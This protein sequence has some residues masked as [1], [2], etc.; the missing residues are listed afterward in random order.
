M[1]VRLCIR[2]TCLLGLAAAALF[3]C[4]FPRA[5]L[6]APGYPQEPTVVEYDA[7][8]SWPKRPDSV[9]PL[10]W[11]SGLAIDGKNQVWLFNKGEDPVQVYTTDGDFVRTWGKGDFKDPHQLRIDP[12]GNIW[13]ADF[14][15]HVVRKYTPEGK[16]LLTLGTLGEKG[17]DDKHFN[18]P[19]DMA[20]TKKGDIF[21]T[22]GYGNRRIVHFDKDGK[23]V[24]AW[25]TYGSGKGQ[26]VLPHAIALD[27]KELL[28][29]ADRNSGRIHVFEQSG[30][31]VDVWSGLVMPWGISITPDDQI[32]V[33]GSSPHWWYRKG[34]YNEFKDQ[35]FMRFSSDGRVRQIWTIPLVDK[36]EDAKPGNAKGVHCIAQDSQGNLFVGDI[37]TERAQ[38]FV[39]VTKAEPPK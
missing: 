38:K 4:G 12:E 17:E 39:P 8:P 10:G 20:V 24:K 32:W 35:C 27:S 6:A 22:D 33:C 31:P 30:A 21:V 25:G 19:T 29:V 11:V 9:K 37:Y 13:L 7:D 3:I 15:L 16:L 2:C 28:Y 1:T 36:K 18:Q 26:F 14:G 5:V 34:Q 23:F